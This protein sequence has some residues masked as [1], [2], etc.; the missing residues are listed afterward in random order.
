MKFLAICHHLNVDLAIVLSV[1][2]CLLALALLL[3]HAGHLRGVSQFSQNLLYGA[4]V[5][6]PMGVFILTYLFGHVCSKASFWFDSVCIDQSNLFVKTQALRAVPAFI[7]QSNTMLIL[8][9]ETVFER[10]WCNY[11][12]AIFA[13]TSLS[14]GAFKVVPMWMPLW[15]L[16]W[17]AIWQVFFCFVFL[18]QH[19]VPTVDTTSSTSIVVS[20]SKAYFLPPWAFLAISVPVSW[21]CF[22]KLK[23]HKLMLDQ[24]S[25]FDLRNA[26]CSLETDRLALTEQVATLF[27]EAFEPP[28]RVAFDA[29]DDESIDASYSDVPLISPRSIQEL[30]E[31]RHVTSY[32]TR[33]EIVDQFNTYVRGALRDTI[34][35]SLGEEYHI[36]FHLCACTCLPLL[37]VGLKSWVDCEGH[38]DCSISAA[39]WGLDSVHE[40][41][42]LD[43]F[44]NIV[45]YPLFFVMS[46]PLMLRANR[47][48]ASTVPDGSLRMALGTL[49]C[50]MIM[51]AVYSLYILE[52]MADVR[53]GILSTASIVGKVLPGLKHGMKVVGVASR[54]RKKAQDFCDQHDCGEGMLYDEMI[55]RE[56][57]DVL[58]IP[59][60]TGL[61]N[62][63][64][65]S[66]IEKGKHIYTEKPM[67]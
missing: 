13:K 53:V 2:A 41:L 32:P 49:V 36:S 54:D 40:F 16:A 26:K 39:K 57:I 3:L 58:Y 12:L 15:T 8:W 7:A 21:F 60:P 27:D 50:T 67:G 63:K 11:E 44:F 47:F 61:R 30:Q 6:W 35:A 56:D 66:A 34:V 43:G 23:L 48:I 4:L 31:V 18:Y 55:E 22:H 5:C 19:E 65:A 1:I 59:L 9:D 51:F 28:L 37:F 38:A 45:L 10:L 24:M 64:I 42:L 25:H 20:G 52:T 14:P 17:L 33:D 46:C 62:D 29:S